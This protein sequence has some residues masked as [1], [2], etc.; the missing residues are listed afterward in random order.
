MF[1]GRR[2]LGASGDPIKYIGG[3]TTAGA[4]MAVPTG[5]M[6]GDFLL[7]F[8]RITSSG[9]SG[10]TRISS[11]EIW[12]RV[13]AQGSTTTINNL[14]NNY[15]TAR[16]SIVLCFRNVN[17]SNPF[18]EVSGAGSNANPPSVT[19]SRGAIV[20][21]AVKSYSGTSSASLLLAQDAAAAYSSVPGGHTAGPTAGIFDYG[22][23]GEDLIHSGIRRASSFQII[24]NSGTYNP[25][26]YSPATGTAYTLALRQR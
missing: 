24:T 3:Q 13:F 21:F 11:T 2:L 7:L 5:T 9:P 23:N 8:A 4:S 17:P 20:T 22:Q 18:Y 10:F 25:G 12:Y 19:S 16:S 15:G 1:L 6:A 26:S 14:Y